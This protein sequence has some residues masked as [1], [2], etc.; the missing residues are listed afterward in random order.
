MVKKEYTNICS[1]GFVIQTLSWVGLQIRPNRKY[2]P[3]DG[4]VCRDAINRVSTNKI[5]LCREFQ[6]L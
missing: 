2:I 5:F 3:R 6:P 4:D 1:A